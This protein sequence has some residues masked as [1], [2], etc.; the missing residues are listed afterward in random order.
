MFD[1]YYLFS[2]RDNL[3]SIYI[4]S[5]GNYID[6]P[7]YKSNVYFMGTILSKVLSVLTPWYETNFDPHLYEKELLRKIEKMS[8]SNSSFPSI[9]NNDKTVSSILY[10]ML[11]DDKQINKDE[12]NKSID[13][14]KLAKQYIDFI[15]ICQKNREYSTC[16]NLCIVANTLG[17]KIPGYSV[18][19]N[20]STSKEFSNIKQ[21]LLGNNQYQGYFNPTIIK[22]P[23]KLFDVE[24]NSEKEFSS[25]NILKYPL[26]VYHIQNIVDLMAVSLEFIFRKKYVLGECQFCKNLFVTHNRKQLY[27]TNQIPNTKT[28]QEEAKLKRQ[29]IRERTKESVKR[30]KNISKMI[31]QKCESGSDQYND[32]MKISAKYRELMKKDKITE[33]E[34]LN[35]IINYWTNTKNNCKEGKCK[36]KETCQ[37]YQDKKR[38]V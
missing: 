11:Y 6:K 13:I 17:R 21:I 12:S 25:S 8:E 29:L 36:Y 35:I 20:P 2:N 33:D 4:C 37:K 5:T 3:E 31:S 27:C 9:T 15:K 1:V 18:Y 34:Y 7:T 30:H 28:C 24:T 32:F 26:H 10:M 38:R 14:F 19:N 22:Q 16:D 23:K